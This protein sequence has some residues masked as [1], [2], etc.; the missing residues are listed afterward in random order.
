MFTEMAGFTTAS[1]LVSIAVSGVGLVLVSYGK[2][3]ARLPQLVVGLVMLVYPY[4]VPRLAPMLIVAA[5]LLLA[6]WIALKR[7]L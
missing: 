5:V 6:L 2:K 3:M 7:G 1:I 4:F